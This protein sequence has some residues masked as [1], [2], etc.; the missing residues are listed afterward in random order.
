MLLLS[1]IALLFV[2]YFAYQ[3][4]KSNMTDLSNDLSNLTKDLT[5]N[6][7]GLNGD[8]TNLNSHISN[9]RADMRT[10]RSF[11]IIS[12]DQWA[13]K[14]LKPNV[15]DLEK[16]HLPLEAGVIAHHSG[17][18]GNRCFTIGECVNTLNAILKKQLE[19][20]S[21]ISY[22]YIIG[23]DGNIY[24]GRGTYKGAHTRGNKDG[25]FP[26]VSNSNTIGIAILGDFREETPNEIA[27][28]A[29]DSLIKILRSDGV[30]KECVT[31]IAKSDI[32]GSESPGKK[33][34]EY[35]AENSPFWHINCSKLE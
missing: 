35:W 24:E 21:D 5:S 31:L 8:L 12:R 17:N 23:E 3:L 19:T 30:L 34:T 11:R 33:L 22:N 10:K 14:E 1:L 9:L 16:L 25:A 29:F 7:T 18:I 6:M 26:G 20:L 2:N 28:Q 13:S 15:A 32:D 27:L 4:T